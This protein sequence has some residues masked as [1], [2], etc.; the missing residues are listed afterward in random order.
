[1][2]VNELGK[3]WINI[4]CE[5]GQLVVAGAHDPRLTVAP[6]DWIFK[7]TNLLIPWLLILCLETGIAGRIWWVWIC[8][9]RLSPGSQGPLR[10]TLA[11]HGWVLEG[12]A[13]N[14][15]AVKPFSHTEQECM[16]TLEF[17]GGKRLQRA[18]KPISHLTFQIGKPEAQWED[19]TSLRLL[20]R[21]TPE[22]GWR[23]W[24]P[25]F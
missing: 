15:P 16:V 2:R 5:S 1:M 11:L 14:C 4:C 22:L 20:S 23:A 18:S 12:T 9:V 6:T 25:G 8:P 3:C 13:F 10:V 21:L 7:L 24:H 17:P 19:V